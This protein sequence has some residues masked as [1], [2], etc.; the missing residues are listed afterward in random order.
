MDNSA[1]MVYFAPTIAPFFNENPFKLEKREYPVEFNYPYTI[2]TVYTYTLPDNYEVAEI[3]EPIA[4]KLPD[5][6]GNFVY[7]AQKLGNKLNISS[8]INIK[9][10]LFL[11]EEYE[12]IKIFFQHI[13][14]KQNELVVLKSI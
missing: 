8:I 2:Q 14:D 12:S 4:V 6:G 9:K 13:I 7:Q 3:P 1:E 5:N 11:P 10:S